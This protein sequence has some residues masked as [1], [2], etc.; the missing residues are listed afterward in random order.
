MMGFIHSD[1]STTPP[2]GLSQAAEVLKFLSNAGNR[3][4]ELRFNE[5]KEFCCHVWSPDKMSDGWAWIIETT[6]TSLV[7]GPAPNMN[8]NQGQDQSMDRMITL[9]TY[10]TDEWTGWHTGSNMPPSAVPGDQNLDLINFESFP[11]DLGQEA[12]DIYSCFNDPSLPLTGVDDVDW[13]E[14]GKLFRLTAPETG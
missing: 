13:A 6:T 8:L 2:E 14:I 10:D 5:L 1:D 11:D 12:G 7:Q 3:A 4:A 9:T